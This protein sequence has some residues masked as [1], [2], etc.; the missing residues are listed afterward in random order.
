MRILLVYQYFRPEIGAGI[1]RVFYTAKHLVSSG[2]NVRVITAVP[3]YPFGKIYPG[4]KLKLLHKEEIGGIE[5]LR[6]LVYPSRNISTLKRL[7]NYF[8]FTLSGFIAGILQ[9]NYDVIIASSPP[10]SGGVVGL[11]IALIKNKPLI[12]EAQDVWPGAA[13][14]LGVLKNKFLIS[15]AKFFETQLYKKSCYIIAPTSGTRKLLLKNNKFLN[16]DKVVTVSNSVDLDMFDQQK[17]DYSV[18]Q[19][20]KLGNKFVVLY[21]GTIGLQQGM[22]TLVECIEKLKTQKQIFFLIVGEGVY[23]ETMIKAKKEKKL[24]N[25][26]LLPAIK[27]REVPSYVNSSNIGIALLRKNRYQDAAIAT[28]VFDYFAGRKPAIVSGGKEM[29]EI[30]TDSKSGFWVEGEDPNL[31]SK[32]IL[33]VFE[34]NK[35]DLNKIGQN[36]RILVEKVFN[37]QVQVKQW[38]KILTS[39][40]KELK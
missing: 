23:K 36:G 7:L 9:K 35:K 40:E 1:E 17:L 34:M 4:Y 20:Y 28:K 15:I 8:S 18:R 30:L 10:L 13:I 32:K 25:M 5:V 16:G 26:L 38:D 37:K 31:L 21:L 6:T 14:E 2:H 19:K 27:Y 33:E 12:F 22:P 24:D 39:L 11:L 29:Q 3:N